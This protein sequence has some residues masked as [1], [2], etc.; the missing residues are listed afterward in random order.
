MRAVPS[1]TH[2]RTRFSVDTPQP[3][4]AAPCD[5]DFC[6]AGGRLPRTAAPARS[7][8]ATGGIADWRIDL[9]F[10][11]SHLIETVSESGSENDAGQTDGSNYGVITG[12]PGVWGMPAPE[13]PAASRPALAVLAACLLALSAFALRRARYRE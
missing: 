11:G 8:H 1:D 12:S 4:L 13:V 9:F 3:S 2:I 10:S 7:S 6:P 5:S